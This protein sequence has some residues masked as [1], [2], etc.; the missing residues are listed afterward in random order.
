MC[1]WAEN[2]SQECFKNVFIKK[3]EEKICRQLRRND[4]LLVKKKVYIYIYIY[5]LRRLSD[6]IPKCCPDVEHELFLF[7]LF[8]FL[9][10][11]ILID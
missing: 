8:A 11:L 4:S 3:L 5:I 7:I 10:F 1:V 9:C 6:S 2:E